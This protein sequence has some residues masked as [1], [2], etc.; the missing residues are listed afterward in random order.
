MARQRGTGLPKLSVAKSSLGIAEESLHTF[1]TA[2]SDV[3]VGVHVDAVRMHS[4][5][6]VGAVYIGVGLSADHALRIVLTIIHS[7]TVRNLVVREV[8]GCNMIESLKPGSHA[9]APDAR[10]G[11]GS[12]SSKTGLPA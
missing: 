2:P 12:S 6:A 10:W 7:Q 11:R 5:S 8:C 1:W 3:I 4:P 9:P